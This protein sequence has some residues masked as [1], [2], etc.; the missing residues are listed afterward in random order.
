MELL[1]ALEILF[2]ERIKMIICFLWSLS[3]NNR[4]Q[5]GKEGDVGRVL[6]EMKRKT[7]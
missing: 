3:P 5:Y 2:L 7:D 6:G 1:K 4:R